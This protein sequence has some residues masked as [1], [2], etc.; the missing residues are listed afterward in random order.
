ML[1]IVLSFSNLPFIPYPYLLNLPL[2]LPH[3][4]P[5]PNRAGALK[6]AVAETGKLVAPIIAALELEGFKHFKPACN[7][8]NAL[9]ASCP[10]YPRYPGGHTSDKQEKECTCGTPW[11]VIAQQ[12]MSG[13]AGDSSVTVEVTD[14]IHSVSDIL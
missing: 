2:N 5:P 13:L 3:T 4:T 12:S 11:S 9:P 10:V 8:D 7:S 1:G 14:A 6:Q